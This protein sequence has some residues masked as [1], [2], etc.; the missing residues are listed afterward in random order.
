MLDFFLI[1]ELFFVDIDESKIIPGYRTDHSILLLK[2]D[3]NRFQ[4]GSSYWKFNNS[5]LKDSKYIEEVKKTILETKQIYSINVQLEQTD[6]NSIPVQ[7]L[8]FFY[9]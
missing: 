8:T 6:I 3:F 4:K 2:F 1:S 7:D 9:K 5:L